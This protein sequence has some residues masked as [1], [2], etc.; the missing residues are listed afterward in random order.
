MNTKKLLSSFFLTLALV[1][2]LVCQADSNRRGTKDTNPQN[3]NPM[4]VDANGEILGEFVSFLGS[5]S[6]IA[7]FSVNVDGT[8]LYFYATETEIFGNI[9]FFGGGPLNVLVDIRYRSDTRCEGAPYMWADLITQNQHSPIGVPTIVGPI[10][11]VERDAYSDNV[12]LY[13]VDTS[14]EPE[15]GPAY[16][17]YRKYWD[18]GKCVYVPGGM[19]EPLFPIYP[20]ADYSHFQPPFHVE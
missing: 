3:P 9:S 18:G 20:I 15:A 12:T 5:R 10:A 7:V 6:S 16:H 13:F 4:V 2:P 8:N 11:P 14:A 19:G 1:I 17:E